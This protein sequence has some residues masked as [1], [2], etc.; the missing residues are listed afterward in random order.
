MKPGAH[1]ALAAAARFYAP[2]IALFALTLLIDS[3]AGGGVGLV[4]GFAFVLALLAHVL[5]FGAAAARAAAPPFVARS[6]LA[7]G[8]ATAVAG[9]GLPRL[10]F[11]PQLLEGGLFLVTAAGG[12]LILAVLVGRAPTMRDEEW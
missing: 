11:A 5:V 3:D 1:I 4:A 2:L 6:M 12:A 9:G 10:A 7:L 8:L